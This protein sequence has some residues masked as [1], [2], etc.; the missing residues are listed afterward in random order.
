[1][2]SKGWV[3]ISKN[4]A[5]MDPRTNRINKAFANSVKKTGSRKRSEGRVAVARGIKRARAN[6]RAGL[7]GGIGARMDLRSL[8]KQ[9]KLS[10]KSARRMAIVTR[11]LKGTGSGSA[12]RRSRRYVRDRR[13]RFA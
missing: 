12:A 1:M 9:A 10:S 7:G 6:K 3:R 11:G 13:G 8:S 2:A 4:G 5:G